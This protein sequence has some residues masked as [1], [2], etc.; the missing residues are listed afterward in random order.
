MCTRETSGYNDTLSR[1][2]I[3]ITG[4]RPVAYVYQLSTLFS[5]LLSPTTKYKVN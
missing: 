4:P 5:F 2:Y 1:T 3:A